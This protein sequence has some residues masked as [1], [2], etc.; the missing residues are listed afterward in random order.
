MA[1]LLIQITTVEEDVFL[2]TDPLPMTN[3]S[4][5]WALGHLLTNQSCVWS[6][7]VVLK[8]NGIDIDTVIIGDPSDPEFFMK[9]RGK[10]K[11]SPL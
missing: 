7:Y 1:I 11:M 5:C 2:R 8:R 10:E 3:T 4:R 9:N 6:L